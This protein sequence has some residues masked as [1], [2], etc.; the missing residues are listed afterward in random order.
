M[1]IPHLE[2]TCP[3]NW[4]RC[5]AHNA[6]HSTSSLDQSA[7]R[8]SEIPSTSPLCFPS[9]NN[10]VDRSTLYYCILYTIILYSKGLIYDGH[11]EMWKIN[12]QVLRVVTHYTTRMPFTR[13]F[14]HTRIFFVYSQR[15]TK[16]NVHTTE[17]IDD[18]LFSLLFL[19]FINRR[20]CCEICKI[21]VVVVHVMRVRLQ[22]EPRSRAQFG[23]EY[24]TAF[25]HRTNM[26]IVIPVLRLKILVM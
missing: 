4:P 19:Y 2:Q 6:S 11:D 8:S 7:L 1:V 22:E 16:L 3:P 12:I 5:N 26:A 13:V 17:T 10:S 20:Y 18:F 25:T 9:V 24:L 21:Q 23:H 14:A 15:S